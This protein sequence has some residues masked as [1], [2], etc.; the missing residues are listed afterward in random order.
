[1]QRWMK[2]SRNSW[3]L[4]S[5][6]CKS[7]EYRAMKDYLLEANIQ[8]ALVCESISAVKNCH[9]ASSPAEFSKR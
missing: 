9:L 7:R 1:M 5:P 4:G 6:A 8:F 3:L 2:D